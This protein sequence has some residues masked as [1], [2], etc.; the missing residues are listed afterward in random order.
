[1]ATRY[2]INGPDGAKFVDATIHTDAECANDAGDGHI[3]PLAVE[4]VD[5]LTDPEMCPDCTDTDAERDIEGMID[6]GVCPWCDEYEGEHVGQHASS[7]H[8]D[9]WDAYKG[10]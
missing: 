5:R 7:A 2:Y 1:M 10:R 9:E 3:R 8:P 6:M 4:T